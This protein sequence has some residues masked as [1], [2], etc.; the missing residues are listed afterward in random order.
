MSWVG[1]KFWPNKVPFVQWLEQA[2]QAAQHGVQLAS[3]PFCIL[4]TTLRFQGPLR[5]RLEIE[6]FVSH[7]I[8]PWTSSR[9]HQFLWC[10]PTACGFKWQRDSG[11]GALSLLFLLDDV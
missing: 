6:W 11:A 2:E 7:A 8:P 5:T 9:L 3:K 1:L 4:H 10:S